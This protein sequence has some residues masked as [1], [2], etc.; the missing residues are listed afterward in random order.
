MSDVLYRVALC[1]YKKNTG[2]QIRA[3]SKSIY[4]K[5]DIFRFGQIKLLR[6]PVDENLSI[7]GGQ[8]IKGPASIISKRSIS[9]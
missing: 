4:A 8:F 6:V 1:D 9:H 3:F 5:P 7:R 2:W